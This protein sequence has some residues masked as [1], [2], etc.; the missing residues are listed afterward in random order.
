MLQEMR[1]IREALGVP[2]PDLTV[3]EEAAMIESPTDMA[4]ALVFLAKFR[5]G[6]EKAHMSAA[7]ATMQMAGVEKAIPQSNPPWK[8]H[9]PFGPTTISGQERPRVPTLV[10]QDWATGLCS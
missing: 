6:L 4:E 1:K 5:T 10:P 3:S 2:Q 9:G 8:P 7:E